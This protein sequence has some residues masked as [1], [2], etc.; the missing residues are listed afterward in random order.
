M[1][2]LKIFEE[3]LSYLAIGA[4][5]VIFLLGL[6][7]KDKKSVDLV[8]KEEPIERNVDIDLLKK[9]EEKLI[10]LKDLYKQE[11]IDSN[12]YKKKIELIVKRVEDIF[13]KDFSSFPRFQQ[14]IVMESL[15]KDIQSKVKV[16]VH[17]DVVGEKSIDSLIDAV[18]KRI[19]RGKRIWEKKILILLM[20]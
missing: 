13:G 7:N 2:I 6:K 14:K 20:K 1:D 11:L 9:Y 19:N 8:E 10:V 15:K 18:D 3:N 17:S 5:L 4:I 16:K 12:L